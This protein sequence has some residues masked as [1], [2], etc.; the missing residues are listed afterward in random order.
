MFVAAVEAKSPSVAVE[1]SWGMGAQRY[2]QE[3]RGVVLAERA[4]VKEK[5]GV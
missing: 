3:L 4:R 2:C 5:Y 1:R